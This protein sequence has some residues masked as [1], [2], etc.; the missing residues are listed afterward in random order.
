MAVDLRGHGDSDKPD[1]DYGIAGFV[2][3][4]AWLVREIGLEKP[5]IVGHSMGGVIGLNLV[6]KH[7]DVA[8]ALVMVDS[9]VTP[10]P[11]ALQA[12][13]DAVFAGLKS[14]AYVDIAKNFV[15]TFMFRPDSDAV[16]KQTII[17]G[18]AEA[19]QRLMWSALSDTLSPENI[20]PGP[21]PVPALYVRAATQIASA[22]EIKS[23]YPGLLLQDIDCAHFA[24]MERPDEFNELL[25]P[26]HRG[27]RMSA[28][29]AL[30][31]LKVADF[32]WF[33]AGP[34]CAEHLAT[35]G[36]TVVRVESETHIDALR[37]VAP[38]A[39]GKTG[40]NVSGYFN[41]FNAGK[42][43]ITINLNTDEGQAL[44]HEARRLGGR[45]PHEH[46]PSRHRAL[47]PDLR[48]AGRGQP[49]DHR[50]LPADAG[51]RGPAHGLPRLRRGAHADHRLQLPLRLPG[52]SAR[53]ASARTTRTTS[54][55]PATR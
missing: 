48:Q 31:G 7:P 23:R 25:A 20:A 19:P 27:E 12:T 8:R 16:L 53:S 17:E 51:V 52:A 37:T 38:F 2:D 11:D 28:R 33:G 45:L 35:Y 36:A 5:V 39:K 13:A 54:S 47:G 32:S 42:L 30:D 10:L 41:N 26:L 15:N 3:D 18:M 55:T 6:R 14:P 4:V 40:Y 50:R 46:H 43:G 1:Q 44:A 22:D 49:A 21:I 9:P 34:I 24:Q 29:A